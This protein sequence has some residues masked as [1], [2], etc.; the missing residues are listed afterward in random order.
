MLIGENRPYCTALLWLENEVPDMEAKIAAMN[1][2]LSHP[3][4]IRRWQVIDKPLSI[5]A[6]ELTH[7]LKVKRG[8]VMDHYGEEIEAMYS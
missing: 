4:Q 8:N 6:G 1:A 7:N 5:Q 3:E 2:G